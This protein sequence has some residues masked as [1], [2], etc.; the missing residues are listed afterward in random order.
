MPLPQ[1]PKGKASEGS[2][3][4]PSWGA[5][6]W[7]GEGMEEKSWTLTRAV[8]TSTLQSEVPLNCISS[9]EKTNGGARRGPIAPMHE[10][11]SYTCSLS[12]PNTYAKGNIRLHLN[13]AGDGGL[14]E[15]SSGST[16]EAE[17]T[18]SILAAMPVRFHRL[19]ALL[20]GSVPPPPEEP[21]A[22]T[23]TLT[24]LRE[25]LSMALPTNCSCLSASFS[26]SSTNLTDSSAISSKSSRERIRASV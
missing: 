11:S 16:G 17:A 18:L 22:W 13:Y 25:W 7:C 1:A 10:L 9:P 8:G 5:F 26:T 15:G 6:C 21:G 14:V 12:G 24:F 3:H 23:R 19:L 4:P 2:A 20:D